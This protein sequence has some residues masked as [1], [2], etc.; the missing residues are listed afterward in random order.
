MEQRKG[1]KRKK[2]IP[3][4]C[5]RCFSTLRFVL[6][7]ASLLRCSPVSERC[8]Q[9]WENRVLSS[10]CFWLRLQRFPAVSV[11]K[12]CAGLG[13]KFEITRLLSQRLAKLHAKF[14]PSVTSLPGPVSESKLETG[15]IGG[16]CYAQQKKT[17]K[18]L[19]CM[20]VQMYL[21]S[22]CC[23]YGL[24]SALL[25]YELLVHSPAAI[26]RAQNEC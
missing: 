13:S 8:Y 1:E 17:P 5:V 6:I 19:L 14:C 24:P 4:W 22:K 25:L 10:P 23:S 12:Q 20:T 15:D 16:T 9:Q 26:L 7:P 3:A 11:T 21:N 2:T 18:V